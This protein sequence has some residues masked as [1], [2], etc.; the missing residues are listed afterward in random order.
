MTVFNRSG[1]PFIELISSQTI[2]KRVSEL[3]KEIAR[4]YLPMQEDL[5]L[6][7][8]LQGC[9]IF[10]SD[11]IR[12]IPLPLQLDF[13]RIASY[14]NATQSTGVVQITSDLRHSIQNKHVLIVEDIIDTGL[15]AHYLLENFRTRK[16]ASLKICSL[17]H[18][19]ER[20]QQSV[21]IDYL[22][23]SVPDHFVVGYG[24]DIRQQYRNL[25]FIGY[26]QTL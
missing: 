4:D 21:P 15:T 6:V 5:V 9:V 8:V 22:G 12:A 19:P 26:A 3:G 17:L 7:G 24:L 16:P 13:I 11:L 20:T 18:K 23:F 10:L 1:S 25:S 14:G 2:A